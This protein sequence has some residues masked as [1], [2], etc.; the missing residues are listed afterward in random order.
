MRCPLKRDPPLGTVLRPFDRLRR[1]RNQAEDIFDRCHLPGG[2]RACHGGAIVGGA[3]VVDRVAD[4]WVLVGVDHRT[5]TATFGH[6]V[7]DG[8]GLCLHRTGSAGRNVDYFSETVE[9]GAS[10]QVEIVVDPATTNHP[11][12]VWSRGEHHFVVVPGEYTVY[13][14]TSSDNAPHQH[15]FT[16]AG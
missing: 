4:R 16:V 3:I 12:S 2:F 10:G 7:L 15:R 8:P 13:F 5:E 6:H 1:P 11:L 9:P 14:G